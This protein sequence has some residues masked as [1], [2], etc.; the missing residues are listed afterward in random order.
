[1]GTEEKQ[2]IPSSALTDAM[3]DVV[4]NVGS[5]TPAL[6]QDLLTRAADAIDAQAHR[7]RH[8]EQDALEVRK[9]VETLE[10]KVGSLGKQIDAL[11]TVLLREFGGPTQDE[12]ACEMAV[13]VMREQNQALVAKDS[14]I[15]TL[16]HQV[17]DLQGELSKATEAINGLAPLQ[18]D[19]GKVLDAEKGQPSA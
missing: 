17:A 8:W 3:R 7:L 9:T 11:A 10:Q 19:D 6:A 5:L 4:E 13:R 1:M 14:Q 16:R 15:E 2:Q 12:S 18:G